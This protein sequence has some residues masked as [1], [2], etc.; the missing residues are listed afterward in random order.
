MKSADKGNM[1]PRDSVDQL[2]MTPVFSPTEKIKVLVADSAEMSCGFLA[3]ALMRDRRFEASAVTTPEE[4]V[5]A[6]GQKVFNILLISTRF[7]GIS[8]RRF[9][10]LQEVRNAYPEINAVVLLESLER[11]LVVDAFRAGAQ[12]VFCRADS[13]QTLCKCIACV[14]AGQTW[15]SSQLVLY[16]IDALGEQAPIQEGIVSSARTLSRREEEI[17]RLA[18]HGL[19]NRQISEQLSLSEHTVKNYLFR[20]FEKLGVSTRVELTLYALKLGPPSRPKVQFALPP[21]KEK[22]YGTS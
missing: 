14:H 16:L 20:V 12:G 15:A 22:W 8:N 10:L 18:A 2:G 11:G 21:F 7:D 19:S 17:A 9:G 3:N 6:L 1:F 13:F 5:E 4:M